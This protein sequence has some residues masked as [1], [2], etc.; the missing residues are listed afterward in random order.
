MVQMKNQTSIYE[1]FQMIINYEGVNSVVG[2]NVTNGN[3]KIKLQKTD[4]I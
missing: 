4:G 3:K 1:T 2:N